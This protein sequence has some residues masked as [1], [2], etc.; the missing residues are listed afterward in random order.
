MFPLEPL[1]YPEL[2]TPNSLHLPAIVAMEIPLRGSDMGMAHQCLNRPEIIPFIQEGCGEGIPHDMRMNPLLDQGLFTTDWMRQSTA[3]FGQSSFLVG[4]VFPQGP[5]EGM[6][7]V[8]AVPGGLQVFLDGDE[9][10][11]VQGNAPE[12]LPLADDIDDG[13]GT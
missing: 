5:E 7:G 10:P 2:Q 9:G 12:L 1:S 13:M 3:F 6:G 4:S 8:G 11:R